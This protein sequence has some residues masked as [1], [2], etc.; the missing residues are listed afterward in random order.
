MAPAN[1][2]ARVLDDWPQPTTGAT[3]P[4]VFAADSILSLQYRLANRR[5]AVIQFLLCMY[6]AFGAQNDEALSDHRLHDRGLEYYSVHEVFNSSLIGELERRNSV[7]PRH[8][9][10]SYKKTKHYIFT[11]QD[12]TLECVVAAETWWAPS[13]RVFENKE[14]ADRAWLSRKDG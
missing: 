10:E 4:R 8:D 13:I 2:R 1:E 14:E 12:S 6:F 7:H 11:F 9:P 5:I 3:D